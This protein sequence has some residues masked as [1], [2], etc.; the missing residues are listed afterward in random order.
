MEISKN[1]Q[2][3]HKSFCLINNLV[4]DSLAIFMAVLAFM[5]QFEIVIWP[6]KINPKFSLYVKFIGIIFKMSK[7]KHNKN[8]NATPKSTQTLKNFFTSGKLLKV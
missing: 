8:Q 6:L 7:R 5:I 2:T 1:S 4:I 3:E